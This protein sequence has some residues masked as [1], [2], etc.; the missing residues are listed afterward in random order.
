MDKQTAIAI[1]RALRLLNEKPRFGPRD[2]RAGFDSYS[3]ASDL[4]HVLATAGYKPL[5]LI[6]QT[7]VP[8]H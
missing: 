8:G 5:E 4:E 2:R 3:V 6:A 1:A 7:N